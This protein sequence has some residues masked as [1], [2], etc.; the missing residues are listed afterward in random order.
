MWISCFI[1][2]FTTSLS[3]TGLSILG[4]FTGADQQCLTDTDQSVATIDV[5]DGSTVFA[6]ELLKSVRRNTP[7]TSNIIFSPISIWSA[8]MV[9]YV[10]ARGQTETELMNTLGIRHLT[11]GSVAHAFRSLTDVHSQTGQGNYTLRLANRLYFDDAVSVKECIRRVFLSE[12]QMVDFRQNAEA[13][14]LSINHWVEAQT[15]DKIQNLL[16]KGSV[17]FLTRLAIVNAAYFKGFWES[18]FSARRTQLGNFYVRS[19]APVQVQ[20]MQQ[21]TTYPHGYSNELHCHAVELPYNGDDVSMVV[22]LPEVDVE[23]MI[24]KMTQPSLSRFF[25]QLSPMSVNLWLPKF[26]VE[27]S[28][29]L[30]QILRDVGVHNLFD[31]SHADLSGFTGKADLSVQSAVHKAYIEV[32]E[33]G[34]EAAAATGHIATFSLSRSETFRADHPFVFLI[35][36][37][38]HNTILFGGLIRNPK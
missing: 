7:T 14:R 35:R 4:R 24:S 38:I 10:G 1:L 19:N 26:K 25:S 15:N 2:L 8:L 29:D 28:L 12:I 32:N 33:E 3:A 27:Q 6:V 30:E 34:A 22:L 36:S 21:E 23:E 17:N 16:G 9:V 11:K 20:F 5:T 13:A 37:K 31:S 18:P